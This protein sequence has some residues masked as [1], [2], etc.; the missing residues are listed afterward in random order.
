MSSGRVLKVD[1]VILVPSTSA[2]VFRINDLVRLLVDTFNVLL[3]VLDALLNVRL[4]LPDKGN[5]P[6]VKSTGIKIEEALL[7][8]GLVK[9][10]ANVVASNVMPVLGVDV[11]VAKL[12][13][14]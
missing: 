5:S 8:L 6:N 3:Y 1:E 2:C 13:L 4:T 11:I 9:V 12:K 10:G 14:R 7:E